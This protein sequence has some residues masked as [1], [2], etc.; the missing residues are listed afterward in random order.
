M[1]SKNKLALLGFFLAL[2]LAVAAQGNSITGFTYEY[3][4]APSNESAG[5]HAY[6]AGLLSDGTP[7]NP[8]GEEVNHSKGHNL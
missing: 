3:S 5:P 1:Y 2:L 8:D 7:E 4:I 6:G